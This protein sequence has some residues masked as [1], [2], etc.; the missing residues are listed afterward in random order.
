MLDATPLLRLYASRRAARLAQQDAREAQR[1]ELLRLLHRARNTTFG[2]E[3]G[4]SGISTV[5][6]FQERV[7]LRR[8]DDFWRDYWQRPFPVLTDICWPGTIPYFALTSGTT[9]GKTK[10]IPVSP[11]MNAS[12]RDAALDIL[13]HHLAAHPAS[14]VLAGR[15]FMLGGSTALKREAPGI[16]S[17]DLSGIAANE[18]PWWARPWFFPPARHALTP[19][20]EAKIDALA[21]LSLEEDIRS[22][23][24]TPSWVLLFFAK[25]A[26]LRPELPHRSSSYFPHLELFIHGGVNFAPYRRQFDALFHGSHVDMREVYSASEGFIAIADRSYGEGLRFVADGGIFYEF[27]PVAEIDA[28]NPVRHWLG[29]AE[30]DVDYAIVLSTCAGLWSYVL[31]DTVRF[32]DMDPPRVLIT[33]RLSYSLSAFGEHLIGEE[34]EAAVEAAAASV[35]RYVVDYT[36]STIYPSRP[37]ERGGHLFIVEFATHVDGL[38]LA[39]F[40]GKVDEALCRENQDYRDHRAGDFGMAPPRV[41]AIVPGS[42]AAWLKAEGRLGGQNK[43]PRVLHDPAVVQALRDFLERDHRIYGAYPGA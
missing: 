17:G 31:G 5:P 41:A 7:P 9:T 35:G 12:N 29:S 19:D 13:V 36:V 10:Y 27:V 24:G 25:L 42:F 30:R 34:I 22:L 14:R 40:A 21:R 16:L 43:V 38:T 37:Q 3:H 1:I 15:N 33:G 39:A 6:A 26:E 2:R 8:Y 28:G 23:S 11:A 18:V 4:F 32:V 20:W